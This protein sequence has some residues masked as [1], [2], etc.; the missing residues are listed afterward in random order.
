[1]S[2]EK[3]KYVVEMMRKAESAPKPEGSPDYAKRRAFV[4]ARHAQQKT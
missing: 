1:M 4:E 3:A 2:S